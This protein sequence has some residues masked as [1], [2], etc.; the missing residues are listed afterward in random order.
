M[1]ELE[2]SNWVAMISHFAV[3]ICMLIF[4]AAE[5]KNGG[6]TGTGTHVA[7][8]ILTTDCGSDFL[9]EES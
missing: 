7:F 5:V 2:R 8:W 9:E 6:D 3:N 1:K 4:C